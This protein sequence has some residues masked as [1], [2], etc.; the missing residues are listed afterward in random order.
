M[1]NDPEQQAQFDRPSYEINFLHFPVEDLGACVR[2][3]VRV[4][5]R[6]CVRACVRACMRACA[7][8]CRYQRKGRST[9]ETWC[10]KQLRASMSG[11]C[12]AAAWA[13]NLRVPNPN[14]RKVIAACCC[15]HL[16][17]TCK[18][19]HTA[20]AHATRMRAGVP[21][22]AAK[23]QELVVQLTDLVAKGASFFKGGVGIRR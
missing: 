19:T 9:E 14:H 21:S 5:V 11:L 22:S 7:Y 2:A 18:I 12:D 17:G 20:R 13:P 15:S 1:A 6:V 4:C 23:L 16:W 3:C 8:M 10:I